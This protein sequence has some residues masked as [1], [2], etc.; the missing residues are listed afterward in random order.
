MGMTQFGICLFTELNML[1][2]LNSEVYYLS[3]DVSMLK[4]SDHQ[5]WWILFEL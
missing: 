3:P 5:Q 1:L 4:K 2:V